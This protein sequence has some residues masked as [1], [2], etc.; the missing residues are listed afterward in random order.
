MS[1]DGTRLLFASGKPGI[2][3]LCDLP[4][5]TNTKELELKSS[6]WAPDGQGVAYINEEDHGNLWEQ[7]LDG[8]LRARSR[9]F[10]TRRFSSSPGRPIKAPGAFARTHVRRHRP[11]QGTE[12]VGTRTSWFYPCDPCNPWRVI[13]GSFLP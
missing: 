9:I 5:C 3:I 11:A 1:P 10:R 4:D 7:P 2:S 12:V 8:R 13:R 6:Q